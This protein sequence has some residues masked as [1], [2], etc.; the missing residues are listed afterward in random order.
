[1]MHRGMGSRDQLEQ[2]GAESIMVDRME[3]C[4][5]SVQI[6]L[7]ISYSSKQY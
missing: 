5:W 4:L 2:W 3:I 6:T 1:M 7:I